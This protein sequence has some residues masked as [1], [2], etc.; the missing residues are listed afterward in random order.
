MTIMTEMSSSPTPALDYDSTLILTVEVSDEK[1]MVAAQ[2]PGLARVTSKRTVMPE[3]EE[4]MAAVE[5]YQRRAATAGCDV[6]R[7]IVAY[8]AGRSAFWLARWLSR[9]G[10]EVH[11]IQPSSV[12]VDRRTLL[13]REAFVREL[14]NGKALGAYAGLVA[15]PYSSGGS[16]R[17]QGIS[18][19]GNRRLRTAAVELAWLWLRYQPDSA[20]VRWFHGRLGRGR[21]RVRKILIVALARRLLIALWRYATRACCPRTHR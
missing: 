2:V 7:V 4:L 19:A 12:P 1:W 10:V 5:G 17:E 15:T 18:K 6:K 20:L 16:E 13:V 8:E 9:R 11:V 21:R 14:T 3:A